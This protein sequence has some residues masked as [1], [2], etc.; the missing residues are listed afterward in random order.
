[1]PAASRT[2]FTFVVE[3]IYPAGGGLRPRPGELGERRGDLVPPEPEELVLG[4]AGLG[5]PVA[6]AS[7]PEC[8]DQLASG[9]V[10]MKPSPIRQD[11]PGRPRRQAGYVD[12]VGAGHRGGHRQRRRLG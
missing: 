4:G 9:M 3:W 2:S 6:A 11:Q 7:L 10:Q 1:M 5:G 8:P 12:R